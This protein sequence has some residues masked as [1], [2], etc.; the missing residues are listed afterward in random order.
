MAKH[1]ETELSRR[2]SKREPLEDAGGEDKDD[3]EGVEG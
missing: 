1:G 2:N 3:S